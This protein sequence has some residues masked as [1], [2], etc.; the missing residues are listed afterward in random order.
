ME[1]LK[2][3]PPAKSVTNCLLTRRVALVYILNVFLWEHAAESHSI[4]ETAILG[5]IMIP[6]PLSLLMCSAHVAREEFFDIR[7][8]NLNE[9]SSCQCGIPLHGEQLIPCRNLWPTIVTSP[10]ARQQ[11]GPAAPC[12]SSSSIGLAASKAPFNPVCSLTRV[13]PRRVH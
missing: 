4:A 10:V 8:L 2:F 13:Q 12:G 9:S 11:V 6:V 1:A 3:H 7:M 5:T